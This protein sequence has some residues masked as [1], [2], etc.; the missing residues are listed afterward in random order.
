MTNLP[1]N[2]SIYRVSYLTL[3]T[4]TEK[5]HITSGA[6]INSTNETR[7]CGKINRVISYKSS[8]HS[9]IIYKTKSRENICSVLN[10]HRRLLV[11]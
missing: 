6:N 4:E 3:P 5:C 11:G 1:A 9:K 7:L 2:L 8:F 10:R